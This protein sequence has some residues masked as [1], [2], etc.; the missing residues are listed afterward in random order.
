MKANFQLPSVDFDRISDDFRRLGVTD[1]GSWALIPKIT[2][3]IGIFVA[4]LAV[5]WLLFWNE[6]NEALDNK[7]TEED[8]LK[9]EYLDKRQQ[10][11]NVDIY[12]QQLSEVDQSFGALL[13]Q[14]PNKA[15]MESLL[16]DVNQAGLGRG[17]Q[18]EYFRPGS[19][20]PKDFYAEVPISVKILGTYHDFGAFASDIAKL[21]RIVTLN[22]INIQQVGNQSSNILSMEMSI[23]T[24]R[25]L[26][27]D[28]IKAQKKPGGGG[29]K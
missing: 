12:A 1:I 10:A 9:K 8:K 2:I 23:K 19:E 26:D 21:P 24:F 4:V 15:E 5:A 25:Y 14:L 18:F 3:C 28:D 29:G 6:E 27:S 7:K 17:L 20:V 11:A 22:N 13:R 16:V